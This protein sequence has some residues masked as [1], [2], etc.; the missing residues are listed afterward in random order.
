MIP[1]AV[2]FRQNPGGR[3]SQIDPG[4]LMGVVL[5]GG[6][7]RRMGGQDKGLLDWRGEPMVARILAAMQPL[8]AEVM[9][10]ANRSL[11]AYRAFAPRVERDLPDFPAQGPLSGLLSAMTLA[12]SLGYVALLVCPCDTPA[13][14]TDVLR[15]LLQAAGPFPGR[16]TVT[17]VAGRLHPLHGVFP[18]S[19]MPALAECLARDER[20]VRVFLDAANVQTVDFSDQAEAFLNCNTEADLK[21]G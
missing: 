19:L 6:E 4:G 8:V 5:A 13:L 12:R 15:R 11:A 10:S 16:P 18:V 7:G 1:R 17:T 14:T 9:I 20:R 21:G 2:F 3:V